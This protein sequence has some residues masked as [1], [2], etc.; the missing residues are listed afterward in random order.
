M[1]DL[2]NLRIAAGMTLAHLD[3]LTGSDNAWNDDYVSACPACGSPIDYCQGHGEIGDPAGWAVLHMHDNDEHA[4]CHPAGCD[5]A[6]DDELLALDAIRGVE[7][8]PEDLPNRK[9]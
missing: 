1:T 3:S 5:I 8:H 7:T 6:A 9:A 4:H 2:A